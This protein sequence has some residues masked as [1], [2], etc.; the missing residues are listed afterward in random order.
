MSTVS[1]ATGVDGTRSRRRLFLPVDTAYPPTLIT[2]VSSQHEQQ[3]DTLTKRK[4]AAVL[5]M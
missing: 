5:P 3:L 2:S 4:Y 1:R